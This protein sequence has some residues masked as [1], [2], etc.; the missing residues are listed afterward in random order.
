MDKDRI[1][2]KK[3]QVKGFVKDKVGQATNDA[4]LEAE[5]KAQRIAGK[6]QEGV[7]KVKDKARDVIDE[8]TE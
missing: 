2:G 7:G 8:V 3:E 1:E 5:G 4:E 6:V